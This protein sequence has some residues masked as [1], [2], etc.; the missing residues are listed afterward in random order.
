MQSVCFF[1]CLLGLILDLCPPQLISELDITG[2]NEKKV[3]Y[4]AGLIVNHFVLH[5]IPLLTPHVQESLFF[6]TEALTILQWG[7]ASD[8]VGRKPV[9]LIGLIG[10]TLSM[11]SFGLSRTFWALVVRYGCLC[12]NITYIETEL[13][14]NQS[15]FNWVA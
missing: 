3:G 14:Y 9:V 2:G 12:T 15:V 5:L 6:A 1:N 10:C 4:Y 11:L 7:R 13:S 8:Y